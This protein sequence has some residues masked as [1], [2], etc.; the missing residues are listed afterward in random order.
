VSGEEQEPG[1]YSSPYI[2]PASI[3]FNLPGLPEAVVFDLVAF[4]RTSDSPRF[5]H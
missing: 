3:Y 5:L 4:N 1:K 2:F